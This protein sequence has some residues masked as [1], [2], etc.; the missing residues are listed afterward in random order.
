MNNTTN[1]TAAPA[2]SID[3]AT[4]IGQVSLAVADLARS[5]TFYTEAL[6]FAVLERDASTVT[7]GAAGV[8]LLV[9]TE[10]SGAKPWPRD[11]PDGYTGL[12]HFAIL[13]P[14]RADLGLWLRHWLDLGFP[15]PGQGDHL[16]SEALY[17]S[18]PDGNGIEIYQDRPRDQWRYANGQIKMATDPVDIRGVLAEGARS[19]RSW[20]GLPAGTT[21]GHIHLQVGDIRQAADFY[22]GV[23]GFDI[24]ASMPTALFISAGGYHHHIG[25]N[26][27]HSAGA[28]AAPEGTA[29]LRHFTITLPNQEAKAEVVARISASEIPYTEAD[30]VVVQDPWGTTIRLHV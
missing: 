14:T 29:G 21:V 23:L 5:L 3:P 27:W 17:L 8:P 26:I 7:L 22:H 30:D 24:M 25:L 16:V 6:G 13:M 11:T 18:D 15:L 10:H 28:S 1:H 4:A 2:A 12:Y 19:G 20:T 9:L